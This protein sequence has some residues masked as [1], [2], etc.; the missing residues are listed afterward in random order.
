[1]LDDLKLLLSTGE[2][3]E[4]V[5][6]LSRLTQH[7]FG[8]FVDQEIL[9]IFFCDLWFVF[10]QIYLKVYKDSKIIMNMAQIIHWNISMYVI[11]ISSSGF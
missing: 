7:S 9:L 4:K 8:M 3:L 2:L 11:S 10:C 6:F 1:M 5:V